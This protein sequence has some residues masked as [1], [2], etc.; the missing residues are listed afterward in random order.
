MSYQVKVLFEDKTVRNYAIE[1]NSP[2]VIHDLKRQIFETTGILPILQ[3]LHLEGGIDNFAYPSQIIC[4]KRTARNVQ[5]VITIIG[6]NRDEHKIKVDGDDEILDLK[7]LFA[8]MIQ[9]KPEHLQFTVN[10]KR[11]YD[12]QNLKDSHMIENGVKIRYWLEYPSH[13]QGHGRIHRTISKLIDVDPNYPTIPATLRKKLQESPNDYHFGHREINKDSTRGKYKFFTFAEINDR[14]SHIASGFISL[15]LKPHN[16]RVGIC[17]T[18]R[19]E[20][21]LCDYA[22]YTQSFI[23]VPLYD[24]LAKNAIEYIVNHA[25]IQ[26]VCCT[27]ETLPQVVKAKESCPSLKF[28]VL[29]DDPLVDKEWANKNLKAGYT[30]CLSELEKLGQKTTIKDT[31]PNVDD[32][33][34]ICYT[35]GTTG[36]PKGVILTHRNLLTVVNSWN[37]RRPP[38]YLNDNNDSILSYLP[39]AHIYERQVEIMSCVLGGR[40]GYFS[41]NL[42]ILVEDIQELQPSVFVGVPRVYQKI[43]DRVLS[44]VAKSNFIRRA[45]FNHAYSTKESAID[46]GSDSPAI[47]EKF[48]Y[49]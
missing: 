28:I 44:E 40:I 17:S 33:A 22:G 4:R 23:S 12:N 41:G 18:N 19:I 25:E 7:F 9:D 46:K 49:L 3:R 35:S 10:D 30:H 45:I 8:A 47:W 32:I 14:V 36:D 39:L 37:I 20:W 11:V 31:L 16:T 34:T 2:F 21:S 24:T 1:P 48:V 6:Y 27:K 15:G 5:Y 13:L 42:D 26:I 29:M 38:E 43:Q